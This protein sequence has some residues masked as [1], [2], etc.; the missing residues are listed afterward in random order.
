MIM[1]NRVRKNFVA[2]WFSDSELEI[3]LNKMELANIKN[4]GLY[5]R[6]MALSGYIVRFDTTEIQKLLHLVANAS[7][8]IKMLIAKL[9]QGQVCY[10]IKNSYNYP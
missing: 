3:L 9:I 4:K 10:I 2:V 1:A 7:S 6:K 8:N 5:L